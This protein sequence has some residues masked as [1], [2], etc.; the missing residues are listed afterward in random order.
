MWTQLVRGLLAVAALVATGCFVE[1]HKPAATA[2]APL[3]DT[4]ADGTAAA[5]PV[6]RKIASA[7]Y[8]AETTPSA[9]MSAN[10]YSV[11]TAGI[12][13]GDLVLF[14]ANIDNGSNTTWPLPTA[15]FHQIEQINYGGDG[16]TFFAA[17]AIA[18]NEPAAYA[19]S[20]S[21]SLNSASAAVTLLAVTGADPTHPIETD[22]PKLGANSAPVVLASDGVTTTL[23]S[24]LV[25]FAGGADWATPDETA[26]FTPPAGYDVL[27]E[28]SDK[29][30]LTFQWT[31]QL[32][33]SKVIPAAGATG[34]L[35]G[36]IATAPNVSGAPWTLTIAIAPAP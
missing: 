9:G 13:N 10:G 5:A 6:A 3:V 15:S 14:I 28:I 19:Q 29:G 1:P 30:G 36:S 35:S 17:W 8:S 25:I 26:T 23:P 18:N 24:S 27:D 20:Y 22:M 16:Q 12:N 4:P 32:V 21:G 33:A 7:W 11:P 34:S 31:L 2:D